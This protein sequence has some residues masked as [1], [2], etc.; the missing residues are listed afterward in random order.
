MRCGDHERR[1]VDA[2]K[3]TH[4]K[5][6]TRKVRYLQRICDTALKLYRGDN[7]C[8]WAYV[9]AAWRNEAEKYRRSTSGILTLFGMSPIYVW[10]QVQIYTSA[11]SNKA[12]NLALAEFDE[13]STRLRVVLVELDI[14]QYVT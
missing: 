14:V 10:S 6:G 7:D 12:E 2:P 4:M 13:L 9:D 8:F 3:Q 1:Y 5:L 11:S